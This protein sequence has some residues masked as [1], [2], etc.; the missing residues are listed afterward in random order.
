[1]H[2]PIGKRLLAAFLSLAAVA[3][4]GLLAGS[5]SAAKAK[6][7]SVFP[8]PGTPVASDA[9]TFSFRGLKPKNLGKVAIYRSETK[10]V[11]HRRRCAA[12]RG[13][14]RPVRPSS[15]PGRG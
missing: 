15:G 10:R 2:S 1:M 9:T 7:I 11:G 13:R 6:P 8:V 12:Q 5:A 14:R 3:S 4:F